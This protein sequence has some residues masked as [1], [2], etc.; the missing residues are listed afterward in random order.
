M[1]N[2]GFEVLI[3]VLLKIQFVWRMTSYRKANCCLRFAGAS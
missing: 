3:E 2:A 1:N